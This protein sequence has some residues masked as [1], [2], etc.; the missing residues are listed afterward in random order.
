MVV[1]SRIHLRGVKLAWAICAVQGLIS[2]SAA[3]IVTIYVDVQAAKAAL[4]GGCVAIVPTL[5]LAARV[6][7]RGQDRKPEDVAGSFYRGEAGKFVLTALMFI[8]GVRLFGDQFLP[9]LVTYAA[10]IIAYPA[11]MLTARID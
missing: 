2:L 11:V 4:Y 1:K 8:G 5:Y 9:L 6:Y 7:F 10:C 3:L